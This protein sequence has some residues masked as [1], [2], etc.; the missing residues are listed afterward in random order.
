MRAYQQ[1]ATTALAD[2]C[3]LIPVGIPAPTTLQVGTGQA[4][5]TGA[6]RFAVPHS[7]GRARRFSPY[8]RG[9]RRG[10]R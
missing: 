6:E 8:L 7:P 2:C 10:R 3:T 9:R 4:T 1:H 5:G